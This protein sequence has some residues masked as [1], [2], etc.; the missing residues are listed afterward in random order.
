MKKVIISLVSISILTVLLTGCSNKKEEVNID[1]NLKSGTITTEC[2][3]TIKK[4]N[5]TLT[6]VITANYDENQK[7]INKK[8][9]SVYE[10]TDKKEYD[11]FI[12]DTDNG[13]TLVNY[14]MDIIHKFMTNKNT[15][16]ITNLVGY[17]VLEISESSEIPSTVKTNIESLESVGY[18]CDI[19][20][21][22]REEIGITDE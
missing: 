12:K 17:P 7:I 10:F 20:G 3:N 22:T 9:K 14:N 21:I 11:K 1:I 8:I 6:E 19:T 18:K 13:K 16:T 2:T 4:D 15:K 5:Y